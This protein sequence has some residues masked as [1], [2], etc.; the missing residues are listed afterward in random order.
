VGDD[1]CVIVRV[2]GLEPGDVRSHFGI[3]PMPVE[4]IGHPGPGIAEQGSMDEF[5]RRRG[6]FDVQQ[7]R[8]DLL[9]LDA[10]RPGM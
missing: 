10:A 3:S 2:L 1:R 6:A 4:E 9:Q 5:D 7:D 8:A